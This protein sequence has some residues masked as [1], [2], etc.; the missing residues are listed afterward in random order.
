MQ[1]IDGSTCDNSS[2]WCK[3]WSTTPRG[4]GLSGT[5]LTIVFVAPRDDTGL[6]WLHNLSSTSFLTKY[7]WAVLF[8]NFSSSYWLFTEWPDVDHWACID[9][10]VLLLVFHTRTSFSL[11]RMNSPA[12]DVTLQLYYWKKWW[13]GLSFVNALLFHRKTMPAY[14]MVRKQE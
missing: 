6:N 3:L 13:H 11:H 9:D 2:F 5:Q 10:L 8:N 12:I 7:V 4:D 14:S 1:V